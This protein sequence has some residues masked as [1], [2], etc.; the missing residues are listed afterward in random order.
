MVAAVAR[1]ASFGGLDSHAELA[2]AKE[3]NLLWRDQLWS[4]IRVFALGY[5]DAELG[6]KS[7]AGCAY[8]LNQVWEDEGRPVTEGV[9]KASLSNNC[10]RNN[11]RLEWAYWFADQD[12]DIAALLARKVKPTKTEAELRADLEAEIR[13]EYPKQAEKLIRKAR[14]R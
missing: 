14:S 9:L 12:Q 7:Y 3:A 13:E 6:L 10:E 4:A 1:Q 11:F 2:L 8:R 5:V